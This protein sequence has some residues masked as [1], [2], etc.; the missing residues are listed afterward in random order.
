MIKKVN[1]H[2]FLMAYN[3]VGGISDMPC[4]KCILKNGPTNLLLCLQHGIIVLK[5]TNNEDK[6]NT[7]RSYEGLLN[8]K[9]DWV[10]WPFLK[11]DMQHEY[12]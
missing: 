11:I 7:T 9:F 8:L 12:Y 3:H 4:R 10:K 5:K 1:L 2:A 6:I